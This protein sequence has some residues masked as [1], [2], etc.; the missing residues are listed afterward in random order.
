M[1]TDFKMVGFRNSLLVYCVHIHQ[2]RIQAMSAKGP[3]CFL[4]GGGGWGKGG[5]ILVEMNILFNL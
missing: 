2:I 1:A 3:F 4:L 5:T